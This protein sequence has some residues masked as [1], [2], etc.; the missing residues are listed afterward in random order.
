MT[1]TGPD[2]ETVMTVLDRDG[3]RCVRCGVPIQG[4]RGR[5]W[6]MQHRRPR[7]MGGT[8]RGDANS[9][10][11]LVALCGSGTTGCHGHVESRRAEAYVHGWL[12]SLHVDPAN[13]PVL[14][15]HGSRWVYLTD[16]GEYVD[17]PPRRGAA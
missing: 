4:E 2:L 17:N 12:V 1:S 16:S 8:D 11:N 7:G 9:P 5:D 10:A 6:S 13:V 14:V 3:Y 15:D